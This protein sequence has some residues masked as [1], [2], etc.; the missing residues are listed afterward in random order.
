MNRNKTIICK[1]SIDPD[2]ELLV[3][4]KWIKIRKEET[5]HLARKTGRPPTDL[6][7]NLLTKVREDK[8]MKIVLENSQIEKKVRIRNTLWEQPQRLKQKCYCEQ[9]Y[10]VQRTRAELGRPRIIEHIG[11]PRHIQQTE[12]G[13]ADVSK[14]KSCPKLDLSYINYREK[15]EKELE[16]KIKKIDPFRSQIDE[17][18]IIGKKPKSPQKRKAPLPTIVVTYDP[19]NDSDVSTLYAVKINDTIFLKEVS[20]QQIDHLIKMQNESCH[21]ACKS[22]SYY[23][24]CPVNKIGRSKIF[25]Q[26]LGTVT[27][28]YCWKRIKLPFEDTQSMVFFFNKNENVIFPGQ[29]QEI[30]ITFISSNTGSYSESW[31]LIFL[32]TCFFENQNKQLSFTLYADAIENV[33]KIKNKIFKLKNII[34]NNVLKNIATDL[35]EEIVQK[36]TTVQLQIYP[37]RKRFLEA[38]IFVMKNPV[39]FYHQTEVAKLNE[40]FTEMAPGEPWDLS[41][42]SWRIKMMEKEFE[43]RMKYYE[44]LRKSHR[45][46]LKSWYEDDDL[47]EQKYKVVK[48]ILGQMFDKFDEEF[49]RLPEISDINDETVEKITSETSQQEKISDRTTSFTMKN[50]FYLRAYEHLATAIEMCAGFIS[51]LDLNRWIDFDFCRT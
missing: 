6:A 42:I 25:L 35:L 41:I 18:M 3:W 50:I 32:N 40:I 43:D 21:E 49:A 44:T 13:I 45:E 14:R 23:F 5:E 31:E 27:L 33:A 47:L 11:V 17:I 9:V 10:E 1:D 19:V 30:S 15:R 37:Y 38:E 7:M 4:E 48:Q 20:G 8:E 29:N 39:C 2:P 22:W 12:M 16:P 28:R 46:C 51:S 34:Y 24:N 26:N 36:A